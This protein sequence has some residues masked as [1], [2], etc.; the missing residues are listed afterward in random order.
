MEFCI[1]DEDF[2]ATQIIGREPNEEEMRSVFDQESSIIRFK[3]NKFQFLVVDLVKGSEDDE[4]EETE[5]RW[6]NAYEKP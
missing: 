4:P 1:I 2:E 3:G 6:T 5:Y